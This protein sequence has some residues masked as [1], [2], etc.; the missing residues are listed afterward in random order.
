MLLAAL[1][2]VGVRVPGAGLAQSIAERL[3]C[4]I[5]FGEECSGGPPSLE[6]IYGDQVSEALR[7]Y[8]PGLIYEEGMRA[9]P[10]DFRRCR[11]TGCSDGEGEGE[12][13]ESERGEPVT[14]FV[15][16]V[17][18]RPKAIAATEME[19]GDCSGGRA[20]NLYLEYFFYYP[21][22]A[23]LREVL[24]ERGFHEDDWESWSVRVGPD[25]D[26]DVRASSHNGYNY[27]LGAGNWGSDAGWGPVKDITETVGVRPNGG[28]GPD[29]GWLFVSGGSHAGNAKGDITGE[30]S[31]TNS[32]DIQLIPLEPIADGEGSS[33]A[34]FVVRP[35]WLKD[36]WSDPEAEGTS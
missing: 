6:A 7:R 9:L 32:S 8:S 34:E 3:I 33:S 13:T 2:L 5:S 36:V 15:H 28:W 11:V 29:T 19:G 30:I 21:N 10:I 25:G 24:G 12:V 4:A 17:D 14:A 1:L 18:C 31:Y 27:E 23:T 35:P 26:A 20:G 22:S 16:V